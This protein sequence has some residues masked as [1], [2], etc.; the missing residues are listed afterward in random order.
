ML[1]LIVAFSE[2]PL[3][4]CWGEREVFS[5]QFMGGYLITH[6][7]CDHV[8][9]GQRAVNSIE[10]QFHF[11]QIGFFKIERAVAQQ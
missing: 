2:Q 9:F 5:C 11:V 4:T 1:F 3:F 6:L 10:A 7:G 8:T